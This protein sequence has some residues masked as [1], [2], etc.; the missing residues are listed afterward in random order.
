MRRGS[1]ICHEFSTI[2]VDSP[3]VLHYRTM[4]LSDAARIM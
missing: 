1:L 3:L 2:W 4:V